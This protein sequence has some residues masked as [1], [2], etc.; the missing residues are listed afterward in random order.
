MPR[1]TTGRYERTSFG[2]EEVAAFVPYALPPAEP[3]IAIDAVAER[4][5]AAEQALVRLELAGAMVPSLDWFIYAFVRKEAVL[6]SQIEG[7]QAT[8]V[9]LLT[10]EAQGAAQGGPPSADVEEVCNHLDALAY[11]RAELADPRGLPLSMR[12]LSETHRRLM[13]G[14]RGAEKQPGEVRRSQ[15]WI[16]RSRPGNA[17]YV[18]PPPHALG[19]VLGA[20]EKY[21]HADDA[22]P[23][24]VRAGLLHVRF[25]TIHPYLDGNGRIGRLL[26]TLLLEHWKLLTRPLL[27]LSLF[28]KRHRDEYYRRLTA[29]RVDGDWEGWLDFFLDG[30]ATIADEAVASARELF[31]LVAADRARV[32]AHEGTSVVALRLF[33]LLPR[34]PIVTVAAVMKLL[35]TTKPTAGRAIELL[36]AAGVL[37]E[38]TGKK[39]DRSYGYQGYL[40]RLKVGT[41]LEIGSSIRRQP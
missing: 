8:L 17:A 33:E 31:E 39:R 15:N 14:V 22:L 38:T 35:A 16:G 2:G 6:S 34:H 9:D 37:V 28:F 3:P 27:Y 18:P 11:A 29:V 24:L 41:E 26:V 13:R 4:L 12:L 10:F 1:R 40:D 20:L 32:L 36:V 23:A 19:E 5:R 21:L 25:E 30:V 7:T